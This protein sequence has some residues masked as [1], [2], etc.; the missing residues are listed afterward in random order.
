MKSKLLG[1]LVTAAI[2]FTSFS[3]VCISPVYAA[4]SLYLSPASGTYKQGSQF[5][6]TI[7][8][9]S[10][11]EDVNAV[12][13]NLTYSTSKLQFVKIDTTGTAFSVQYPS[14]GGGGKVSIA[15]TTAGTTLTGDQLV[16]KVVFKALASGST[17]VNFDSG[18]GLWNA[19]LEVDSTKSNGTYTITG[20]TPPPI[21]T[22]D[23]NNDKKV[24]IFDLSILLSNWN[25]T[26]GV[27][28]INKSG[29][30]DIFDLSILLSNWD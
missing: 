11:D 2:F 6:I 13:V 26:G 10:G 17:S 16:A 24:D 3:F 15:R 14:S 1:S 28:D 4:S 18:S 9:N 29:K 12:Q 21:V 19:G 20:T 23:L 7:K 5:T 8:E 30:V 22:G 25:K 27:A